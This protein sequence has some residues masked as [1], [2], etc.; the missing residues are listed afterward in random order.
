MKFSKL[1]LPLVTL[2]SVVR[3]G[4][5]AAAAAAD[6]IEEE[7]ADPNFVPT[8][9]KPYNFKIDYLIQDLQEEITD[10]VIVKNGEVANVEYKFAN[11]EDTEVIIVGVGGQLINPVTGDILANVTATQIG[12]LTIPAGESNIFI[13][14]IGIDLNPDTYLFIPS[15]YVAFNDQLI[16]LGS[17]NQLLTVEDP[18]ISFFNPALLFLEVILFGSLGGLGYFLYSTFGYKYIQGTAPTKKSTASAASTTSSAK[19][20]AKA[21]GSGSYDESWLPATH[22]KSTGKKVKKTK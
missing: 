5:A 14:K 3:P 2:L 10:Q 12:P 18:T 7:V 8:R 20:T 21:T 17:R 4:V 11:D 15:I 22:L 1:L 9:E 13:Q 19:S 6:V 16:G